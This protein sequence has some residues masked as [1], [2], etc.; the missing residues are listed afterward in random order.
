[1]LNPTDHP[2]CLAGS[3]R[4]CLSTWHEHL[5]FA[6]FLLDAVRP[7]VLVELGTHFGLSYG[8][9]CQAVKALNLGTNCFAVDN[10][11]G[12][13]HERADSQEALA[14]LDAHHGRLCDGFS[15]LL[16]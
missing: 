10:R 13:P 7:K 8:G 5:P 4:I 16:P 14:D 2:K 1:M 9:F 11:H 3:E 6:M 15:T 12:D